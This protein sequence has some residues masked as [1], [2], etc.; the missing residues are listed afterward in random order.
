MGRREMDIGIFFGVGGGG[1]LKDRDHW[2]D[3]AEDDRT[4]LKLIL[5]IC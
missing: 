2:E 5:K 3:P 1:D 4:V